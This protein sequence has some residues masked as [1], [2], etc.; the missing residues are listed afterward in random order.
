[1]LRVRTSRLLLLQLIMSF[2]RYFPLP[3]FF[4][5]TWVAGLT[6]AIFAALFIIFFF[7]L[8]YLY[9]WKKVRPP[10]GELKKAPI[11]IGRDGGVV[12]RD[13]RSDSDASDRF[14]V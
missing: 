11:F 8:F 10:P 12:E 5:R 13:N 1:M 3:Q 6:T 14:V 7:F 2:K 9:V 4:L